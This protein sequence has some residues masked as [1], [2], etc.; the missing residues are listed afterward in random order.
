[1]LYRYAVLLNHDLHER[2]AAKLGP[3]V[4]Q[5]LTCLILFFARRLPR[6]RGE[7]ENSE[8]LPT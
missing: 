7:Q 4:V 8:R 3:S 5:A 2:L 1:M 6:S